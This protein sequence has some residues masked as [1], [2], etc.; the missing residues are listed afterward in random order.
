[1]PASALRLQGEN[2]AEFWLAFNNFYV[3]T[4]Y[5]RSTLYAMAVMQLSQALKEARAQVNSSQSLVPIIEETPVTSP[6]APT[7]PTT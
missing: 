5:N 4:T 6:E 1:M 2:G 7:S 3:I